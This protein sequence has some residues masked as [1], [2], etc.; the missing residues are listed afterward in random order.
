MA[1]LQGVAPLRDGN[2]YCDYFQRSISQGSSCSASQSEQLN[3][4]LP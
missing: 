4:L 2:S 1:V 3:L